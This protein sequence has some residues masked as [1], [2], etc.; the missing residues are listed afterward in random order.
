M[1]DAL[2]VGGML[3]SLLNHCDRVK[4]G[5]LAQVV[6]VIAAI[7]TQPGGPA[8]RQ[9]I[10]HPFAHVSKHGRGTVLRQVAESSYYDCK[11]RAAVPHLTSA[12]V[13]DPDTGGVT[14][15]AVNRSLD[16]RLKLTVDLRAFAALHVDEWTTL[17]HSDLLAENTCAAPNKVQPAVATGAGVDDRVLT[18]VLEAA[19]WNVI[20]LTPA[21]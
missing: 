2:V 21:K 7:M 17:R 12:C 5:C 4:I 19:S 6:N 13:L 10:F 9:T 11:D 16:S 14:L 18:A 20:R 8:W 3:I 1:E 15:F